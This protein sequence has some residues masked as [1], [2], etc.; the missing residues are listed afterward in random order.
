MSSPSQLDNP[1]TLPLLPRVV[2]S[3]VGAIITA[4]A[5]Q[6][7]EVI[8]IHQQALSVGRTAPVASFST[9]PSLFRCLECGTFALDT[10]T[11][12]QPPM[13]KATSS[14]TIRISQTI[15]RS[16][17]VAGFYAGLYPS[18]IMSVPNTVTYFSCYDEVVSR[19]KQ[20][21]RRQK[22]QQYD[23]FSNSNV[24]AKENWYYDQ[25]L[26]PLVG[27]MVARTFATVVTSPLELIRTRQA[28]NA[29]SQSMMSEFRSVLRSS[30]S[31]RNP[32][33]SLYKGLG[34][35]LWRDVPF[36]AIYWVGVETFKADV[37]HFHQQDSSSVFTHMVSSFASGALSG[38]IAATC[39]TPFD[40]VK[41]RSQVSSSSPQTLQ[42]NRL[43]PEHNVTC[44]HHQGSQR[45]FYPSE[46]NIFYQ[47]HYIA[48]SEGIAALWSGNVA[49]VLKIGPACAIM[50][51]SYEY[52]KSIISA[53]Q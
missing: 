44:S 1:D 43:F 52:S 2:S 27:G 12:V 46:R 18:L 11:A 50:L 25:I 47:L 34:P 10:T 3:S 15:F 45:M 49:R 16:H 32:V 7:L 39:T 33:A 30:N 51:T 31:K 37:F 8:K 13:N 36:S 9:P 6:P 20:W 22:L 29:A 17:G 21:R 41:T 4:L 42:K 40:V 28:S 26:T 38:M 23:D 53:V 35:T 5:V 48:K 19:M 14:G 24:D